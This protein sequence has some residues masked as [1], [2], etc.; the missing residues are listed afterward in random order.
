MEN[1]AS[2]PPPTADSSMATRVHGEGAG[3]LEHG[4]VMMPGILSNG[5]DQ[6]GPDGATGN[7]PYAIGRWQTMKRRLKRN[8]KS[9]AEPGTG[10]AI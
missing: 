9:R 4:R 1:H 6:P 10:L 5:V 3:H 7:T 2:N 8:E